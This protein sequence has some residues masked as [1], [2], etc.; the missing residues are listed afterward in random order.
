MFGLAVGIGAALLFPILAVAVYQR[1]ERRHHRRMGK[2]K[3][4]KI[5]L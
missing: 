2:R 4:D 3:T 1:R 5:Q